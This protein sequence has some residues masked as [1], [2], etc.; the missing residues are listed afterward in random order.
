MAS[1][2][3]SE[4]VENFISITGAPAT[5][6]RRML[7]LTNDDVS[8]AIQLWFADEDLQRAL[9]NPDP[10][11]ATAGASSAA[12]GASA[13]SRSRQTS[14]P[15]AAQRAGREDTEGVIVID[16]DS[17]DDVQMTEDDSFGQFDDDEDDVVQAVNVA[18]T[19]QEEEDAAMAKRLQEELYAGGDSGGGAAVNEDGVRA[20]MA[21][22]TETLIGPAGFGGYGGGDQDE[23]QAAVLE[24]LRRRRQAQATS[25]SRNPFA[26]SVWEDSSNPSRPPDLPA[27]VPSRP[28]TNS[29]ATRLAELFR[30]PYDLMS[31]IP[32]DEA[33]EEGKEAQKWIM[34]NLQ[35]MSD[36]NCQALN[37]DIWKD[38][39]IRALVRENF[40]FLQYEKND[41][42]AEQYINFYLPNQ[43]HDNPNNYPHVSI[44]DPRTGEQVKVW[45]GIPFPTALEFHAHL[46]EFLDRYSLADDA[47]NPVT[48]AKRPERVIDVDRMTEEEML[49]LAMQNSLE[50]N[51]NLNLP[52]VID[53]DELTRSVDLSS[54]KGKERADSVP[55]PQLSPFA[56]IP[57]D[58]P[59]E[60]PA[61]DPKT[62]TRL[63]VRHPAGRIIR[64]FSLGD[65]VSRIYEWLKAEP[66]PDKEGVEFE[67]K[68]MPQGSDL[69]NSLDQTIKDAGLANGTVMIEFIED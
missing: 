4:D 69:I 54:E 56:A 45:S 53:P 9:S 50:G 21:R 14:R 5:A 35:D 10:S 1:T 68:S 12:A 8:Q 24:Q 38:E 60:E 39:P 30:P 67:L 57:S 43:S 22:T 40:I 31:H 28:P 13:S 62:V 15:R 20:P 11:T 32:L 37:R 16:S 26:Q 47:K 51:A 66:L 33:R 42:M 17:D 23:V 65:P 63:Q 55:P 36:F 2:A 44:I 3:N 27:G 64:R 46:A 41:H 29:R 52:N 59:H 48:K 49:A 58:R 6:A 19:A 34:V 18:R 7:E 25:R 61:T